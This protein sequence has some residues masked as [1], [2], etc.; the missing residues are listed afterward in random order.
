[1]KKISALFLSLIMVLSLVPA[2][3]FAATMIESEPNDSKATATRLEIGQSCKGELGSYDQYRAQGEDTDWYVLTLKKGHKYRITIQ[4]WMDEFA[5]TTAIATLYFPDGDDDSFGYDM[6]DD[7]VDYYDFIAEQSGTYYLKLYNYFDMNGKAEH[8]YT[9]SVKH[10]HSY[11]TTVKKPTFTAGGYTKH[12]CTA[13]GYSYTNNETA[14]KTLA[15]PTVSSVAVKSSGLTVKWNKIANASG[16][17]IYRSKNGGSYSKIKTINGK[18]TV[19][20]KDTAATKKGV[21]YSYKV[22]A[23]AAENGK[24]YTSAKSAAKAPSKTIKLNMSSVTLCKSKAKTLVATTYPA[25]ATVKWTSSK[26]SVAKVDSTGKITAVGK[27]TATITASFKS[28]GKVYKTTCKVTV[29][30]PYVKLNKTSATIIKGEKVTLK[31]TTNPSGA[32]VKW[33]SSNTS[34][35]KV[36]STGKV[37]GLKAGKATITAKIS[38]GGKTYSRTCAVTVKKATVKI[39]LPATP[40][41]LNERSYDGERIYQTYS[42]TGITYTVGDEYNGSC[43]VKIYFSG[44]K[45]YDYRGSGQ[46]DYIGIGW[47]LYDSEGNVADSGNCYTP[48]LAMG[49]TFKNAEEYIWDLPV[50]TYTLKILDSN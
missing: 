14:K 31:A 19:S 47:K 26:K 48:G 11:K 40:K 42:V 2:M 7:G 25:K 38:Y 29:K 8:Y 21:K 39:N 22:A 1:M 13:C 28:G 35:A 4:G 24:T 37:T 6:E 43:D 36:S 41:T 9:I 46:S 16:Y 49:E 23:F 18:S 34:V 44:K 10:I 15:K 27:G 20:Y 3:A 32:T 33:S 17:Y 5:N 50:G 30:N 12:T 45:T